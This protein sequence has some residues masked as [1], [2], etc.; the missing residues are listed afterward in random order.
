[1]PQWLTDMIQKCLQKD[2]Q[3]RFNDGKEV[4]EYVLLNSTLST[5]KN[6]V[7]GESLNALQEENANLLAE[8]EQLQQS[9]KQY[10][11]RLEKIDYELKMLHADLATKNKELVNGR[12]D[13]SYFNTY[14]SVPVN[15]GVSKNAF[16]AL[17]LLTTG[18]GVFAAYS[19][20]QKSDRNKT[21]TDQSMTMSEDSAAANDSMVT[22]A[23][24][25]QPAEKRKTKDT[26]ENVLEEEGSPKEPEEEKPS[27]PMNF[28]TAS[29]TPK[30]NE[31]TTTS[32]EKNLGSYRLAVDKAYFHNS[33]DESTRRNA[34]IVHWN[35]VVLNALDERD[36]FVYIVFT[37]HLGQTSRGWI[38][39]ADL[40]QV[41]G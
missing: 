12:K 4:Y 32:T 22:G 18:L 1:V 29:A 27:D 14:N 25:K 13:S 24:M 28:D 36:G 8:K 5:A 23:V 6:E 20:F 7:S 2:P 21:L 15:K 39:K 41:G 35:N 11:E 17:L 30:T 10:Q 40:K 34:F 33:P 9:V 3:A 19:I 38:R 26:V 31:D 16:I 37:N